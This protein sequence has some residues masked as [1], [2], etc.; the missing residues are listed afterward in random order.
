MIYTIN[1]IDSSDM[2]IL[3]MTSDPIKIHRMNTFTKSMDIEAFVVIDA[4]ALNLYIEFD[5]DAYKVTYDIKP[6]YYEF[7]VDGN[8]WVTD[9]GVDRT[10]V[11]IGERR[12]YIS[13]I[14]H[15]TFDTGEIDVCAKIMA[16]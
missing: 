15:L 14:H 4:C 5:S 3:A 7:T 6:S 10:S 12:L 2:A 8:D 9:Y 16:F 1:K 11:V 13:F